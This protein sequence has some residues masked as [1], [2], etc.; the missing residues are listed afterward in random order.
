MPGTTRLA[1]LA[2]AASAAILLPSTASAVEPL[3]KV[4]V[5]VGGYVAKFDTQVRADGQTASGTEVDLNRDLGLDLDNTVAYV[6]VSWRPLERHEFGITYFQNDGRATRVIDRDI[7]FRG[8][9]YPVR[10]TIRTAADQEAYGA[11][12]TWWAASNQTWALGPMV[13]VTWYRWRIG[14]ALELDANGNQVSGSLENSVRADIP[15]PTIG[16]SWRWVPAEDWRISADAGYFST[17]IRGI[18]ADVTYGRAGVEWF[19]WQRVGVSLDYAVS[20]ID[21]AAA[22]DN[23]NGDVNF[24]DSGLRMGIVYKF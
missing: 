22:T 24:I 2:F 12:Y 15:A 13:G 1:V 8:T 9:T 16:A 20:K 10:S 7:V 19:P 5:R 11:H 21:A 3:D 4:S 23:F 6:A 18:D 14:A 17:D